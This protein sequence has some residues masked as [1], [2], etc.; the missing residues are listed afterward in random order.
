MKKTVVLGSGSPRRLAL[1]RSIGVEPHV[2]I[3]DV[4]ESLHEGEEPQAY[5]RRLASAKLDAVIG[6]LASSGVGTVVIAA[7]TTVEV[8]DDSGV[9]RILSKPADADEARSMLSLLSVECTRALPL[10]W[11]VPVVGASSGR[12]TSKW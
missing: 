4:D 11:L 1:L 10:R 2:V 5:V 7:D 9:P 12:D 8:V 6:K 3:P